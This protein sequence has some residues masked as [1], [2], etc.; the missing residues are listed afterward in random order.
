MYKTKK[1]L[2][3][4]SISN[5][6]KNSYL[7]SSNGFSEIILL[8]NELHTLHRPNTVTKFVPYG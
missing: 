5:F 6:D 8:K 7:S 2:E 3:K 4:I 1:S